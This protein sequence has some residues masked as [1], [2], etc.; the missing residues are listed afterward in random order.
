MLPSLWKPAGG[1]LWLLNGQ[2]SPVKRNDME[3]RVPNPAQ[4]VVLVA[5]V[6]S[7]TN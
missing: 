2:T 1:V 3:F 4:R 5:Y 7:L 6:T